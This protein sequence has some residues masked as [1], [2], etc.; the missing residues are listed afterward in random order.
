LEV[1]IE[2]R[3]VDIKNWMRSVYNN[4]PCKL[5]VCARIQVMRLAHTGTLTVHLHFPLKHVFAHISY[6]SF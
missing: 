2:F 4:V 1:H 6:M 5:C 3:E